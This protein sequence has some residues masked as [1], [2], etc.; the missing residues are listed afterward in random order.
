MQSQFDFMNFISQG[1]PV[2]MMVALCLLIM[3]VASWY[4]MVLKGY[5]AM[6]LNRSYAADDLAFWDAQSL[7]AAMRQ[8]DQSSPI[9]RLAQQAIEATEHHQQHASKKLQMLATRTSLS[10]V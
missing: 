2:T 8:V 7:E 10:P 9:G 1:G 5:Q 4:L 3:S 6:R